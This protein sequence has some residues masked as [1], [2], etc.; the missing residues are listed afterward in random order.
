M[1][2]LLVLFF[3]SFALTM[4][5]QSP[6]FTTDVIAVSGEHYV[7]S[8]KGTRSVMVIDKTGSKVREWLFDEPVTGLC[9]SNGLI[10]A[11]NSGAKGWLTSIDM[12]SSKI[13]YKTES[14]NGGM[15]SNF[16]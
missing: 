14:G 4:S 9:I 8:N 11:T 13:G 5:A 3:V 6:M 10:Y 2:G 16:K 12:E 15:C 7:L 1:K